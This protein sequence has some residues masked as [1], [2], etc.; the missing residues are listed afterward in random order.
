MLLALAGVLAYGPGAGKAGFY[1]DDLP[2]SWIRYQLGPQAMSEY[3]STN[4]PVWG[5]LYQ[6]TTRLLPQ[7]PLYWQAFAIFWRIACAWLVWA[8]G[9]ELGPAR[10]RFALA[11]GALF[12]L[13]PG[14]NGQWTAYLYSHFFIVLA[15]FLFSLLCTLL[16]TRRASPLWL[17]AG[18][19]TSALNL[20]MM[21]YFFILELARGVVVFAALRGEGLDRRRR[22]RETLSLWWPYLALFAVA[23]FSR[24]FVFNNQVYGFGLLP[25]LRSDPA[26][27]LGGLLSN[28]LIS[29]WTVTA[30][31]WLQAFRLPDPAIHG[32][33]TILLY[34][35]VVLSTAAGVLVWSLND[36]ESAAATSDKATA[37][38]MI[39]LGLLMLPL[40]SA[41]FWLIDLPVTLAFPANR[42]TLPSI[43]G[44]SLILAGL[45]ELFRAARLGLVL[46]VFLAGMAAGRQF[47]WGTDFV[48]DW[49]VQKNLFWQMTWRAPSLAPH[50]MVLLNEGALSFYADN[51]LSAALNWI[52]APTLKAG[53]EIPYLLFYP[54]NRLEGGLPALDFG[55]DINYDYLAGS[56]H[57]STSQAVAFYFMPPGCLRLLDPILDEGNRLIPE[58][59]LMREAA[60]LSSPEWILPRPASKMPAVYGP[61][62]QHGW[63]YYFER[64]DLA[65]QMEDWEQVAG[66]GDRAFALKDYPNDPSER[67]V[68]IEG[69]AHIGAWAKAVEL[70]VQSHRVSPAYVDPLLCRLWQ[71]I[72][73]QTAESPA[74]RSAMQQLTTKLA[75][76]P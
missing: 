67:F 16:S 64:A 9:R 70:S 17:A 6:A 41:P 8:I 40:A 7:V 57:G 19:L 31:A 38:W 29:F 12:L 73:A 51:S 63:C 49:Q 11:L 55:A 37:W 28:A 61:E 30:G 10:P 58:Q 1:W 25:R 2:M 18:L 60:G 71:R 24:L 27:T 43:L 76:L 48:R 52:Y 54:T 33:R 35:L 56:F 62:P 75:C 59:T 3:F 22:I 46:L 36:K 15:L 14:F 74:R 39:A 13:Y 5:L 65:R 50:T 4:R 45:L 53:D 32:P 68:F 26:G 69:Y 72:Q 44:A 66:L 23:V 20:W 42:F 47:L 21:E 34:A